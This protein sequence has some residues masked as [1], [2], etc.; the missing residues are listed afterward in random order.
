MHPVSSLCT[1][2]TD[3]LGENTFSPEGDCPPNCH[4]HLPP[5]QLHRAAATNGHQLSCVNWLPACLSFSF[6]IKSHGTMRMELSRPMRKPWP[7]YQAGSSW[8]AAGREA[9]SHHMARLNVIALR[10][11]EKEFKSE[12][13]SEP[14]RALVCWS[15]MSSSVPSSR[16]LA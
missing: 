7:S 15:L 12:R 14:A 4:R 11:L 2:I 1:H 13:T 5:D 10:R 6:E 3:T 8:R 16:P 9:S